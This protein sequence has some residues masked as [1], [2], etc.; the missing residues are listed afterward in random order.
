MVWDLHW[1]IAW[2]YF[3][4]SWRFVFMF[5]WLRKSVYDDYVVRLLAEQSENSAKDFRAQLARKDAD[6]HSAD[7][8]VRSLTDQL[9]ALRDANVSD[10]D[11]IAKLRLTIS[12]LD[13]EKDVLQM[14]IDEK[15][16]Q[17]VKR[18][19]AIT[20]KVSCCFSLR[21]TVEMWFWCVVLR[22][23]WKSFK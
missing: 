22:V 23:D 11:E 8:R 9:T 19:D 7:E 17:E 5:H 14:M 2:M 4:G 10:Q 6:L 15:T 21:W 16:E 3:T 13:Q 18:T 12:K 1:V 20:N